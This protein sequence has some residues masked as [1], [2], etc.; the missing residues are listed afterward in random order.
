MKIG[1]PPGDITVSIRNS[2]S[3]S[4]LTTLNILSTGISG[5]DWV[6]FDIPD[7]S[8]VPGDTYY[9]VTRTSSGD[10]GNSYAWAYGI[11]TPYT[12]GN[13]WY[14]MNSGMSWTPLSYYDFC[15]KTYG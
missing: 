12:D 4:D 15:F 1:S 3:G 11:A 14:S 9:I 7:I 6:E 8:V 13:K 2:L 5:A 10:I